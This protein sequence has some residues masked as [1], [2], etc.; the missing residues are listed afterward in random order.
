MNRAI[1]LLSHI[2]CLSNLEGEWTYCIGYPL[3]R[4]EKLEILQGDQKLTHCESGI[5]ICFGHNLSHS[6]HNLSHSGHKLSYF[7]RILP[8]SFSWCYSNYFMIWDFE[9]LALNKLE[10]RLHTYEYEFSHKMGTMNF[11]LIFHVVLTLTLFTKFETCS[12]LSTWNQDQLLVLSYVAFSSQAFSKWIIALS[13]I[14]IQPYQQIQLLITDKPLV[15]TSL[16]FQSVL[17]DSFGMPDGRKE[18][19]SLELLLYSNCLTLLGSLYSLATRGCLG[20]PFFL[21]NKPGH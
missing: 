4:L 17:A 11:F 8:S 19:C 16:T 2:W 1:C 5:I 14:S 3:Y 13:S 15:K 21:Q 9:W 20:S 10:V 6:S 7:C 18:H 12:I